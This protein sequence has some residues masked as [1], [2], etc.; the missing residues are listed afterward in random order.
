MEH[1]KIQTPISSENRRT[2]S[3]CRDEL[4]LF[5]VCVPKFCFGRPILPLSPPTHL[6]NNSPLRHA[7]RVHGFNDVFACGCC[8]VCA[9][10]ELDVH[11]NAHSAPRSKELGNLLLC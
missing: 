4:E 8:F 2:A 11:Q 10:L 3:A 1:M 5:F 9:L 6:L 7:S